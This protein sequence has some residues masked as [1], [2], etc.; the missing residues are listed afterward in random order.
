[1][2][3]T[4][5]V[6]MMSKRAEISGSGYGSAVKNHRLPSWQD[7][8]CQKQ[9]RDFEF[10]NRIERLKSSPNRHWFRLAQFIGAAFRSPSYRKFLDISWDEL[11]DIY[12][13]QVLRNFTLRKEIAGTDLNEDDL[14]PVSGI[15]GTKFVQPYHQ[16]PCS[17]VTAVRRAKEARRLCSPND[18]ILLLG[19]DDLVCL[20]LARSGFRK[21]TV[22]DIDMDLLTHIASEARARKYPI[23]LCHC[24]VREEPPADLVGRYKLVFLDPIYTVDGIRIFLDSALKASP[25]LDT[26]F[27]L[28]INLISLRRKGIAQ[29]ESLFEQHDLD[30]VKFYSGFNA[31]PLPRG[32]GTL[33]NAIN[34]V[35][36]RGALISDERPVISHLTSDGILL[37]RG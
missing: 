18:P 7:L 14:L 1:M 15:V 21:I 23:A 30:I 9:H 3:T 36:L 4:P 35:V 33:I 37:R 10:Q 34:K 20:E 13:D 17:R 11:V 28:S 24:D 19:D 5:D 29:V 22:A 8:L 26:L 2:M 16:L 6:G 12:A 32:M 25:D 27:F 31:Y